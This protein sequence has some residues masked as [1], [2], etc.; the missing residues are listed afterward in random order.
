MKNGKK[1]A[2]ERYV[3]T[4]KGLLVLSLGGDDESVRR[5]MDDLELYLR[6]NHMKKPGH[7]GAIIY[8]GKQWHLG[9]VV[10]EKEK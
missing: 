4:F 2:E 7:C 9:Y 6:R 8:D 10:Q 5:V 3:I 1:K